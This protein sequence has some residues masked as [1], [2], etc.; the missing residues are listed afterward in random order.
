MP[1]TYVD[2]LRHVCVLSIRM[3]GQ[4]AQ[5]AECYWMALTRDVPFNQYGSDE[6]TVTAA[7]IALFF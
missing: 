2:T 4:A 7:G 1:L 3:C 5:M 6:V